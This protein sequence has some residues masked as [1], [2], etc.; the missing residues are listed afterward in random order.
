MS[1]LDPTPGEVFMIRLHKRLSTNPALSWVNTYEFLAGSTTEYTN[2]IACKDGLLELEEAIHL[3][4]VQFFK[5]VISTWVEDGTPYDPTS[6]VSITEAGVGQRSAADP[7][8][9]NVA[10]RVNRQVATG[11]QGKLFYRRVLAES[12]VQSPA[13]SA[14]LTTLAAGALQTLMDGVIGGTTLAP[15]FDITDSLGNICMTDNAGNTRLVTD[16]LVNGVSVV[17]YNHR[18]FDRP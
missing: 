13:G 3:S 6:F 5:S 11:R 7:E 12:E 17:S 9:L 8:P 18:Y 16:L 1:I 2:L 4:D 10:L 14:S 15:Y